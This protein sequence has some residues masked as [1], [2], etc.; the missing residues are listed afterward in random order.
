MVFRLRPSRDGKIHP[1]TRTPGGFDGSAQ[2]SGNTGGERVWVGVVMRNLSGVNSG[3]YS[4]TVGETY[5]NAHAAI[6][7]STRSAAVRLYGGIC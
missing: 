4:G 2:S 6:D 7:D 5:K 3:M 1:R